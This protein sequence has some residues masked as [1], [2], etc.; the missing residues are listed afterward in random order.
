MSGLR[1]VILGLMAGAAAA[2]AAVPLRAA[3]RLD[4]DCCAPPGVAHAPFRLAPAAPRPS[5]FQAQKGFAHVG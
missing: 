1:L 4:C 5:V 2:C 3:K